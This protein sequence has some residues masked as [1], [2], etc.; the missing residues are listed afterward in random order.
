MYLPRYFLLF[1]FFLLI[2][3]SGCLTTPKTIGCC[4]KSRLDEG[5]YYLDPETEEFIDFTDATL[6]LCDDEASGTAG[7]CAVNFPDNPKDD[8]EGT[9]VPICKTEELSPCV[10][11]NCEA[12]LCGDFSFKPRPAKPSVSADIS[13]S[14]TN[15][16]EEENEDQVTNFYGASCGFFNTGEPIFGK[17]T[18]EGALA[19][20]FRFGFGTTF[21]EYEVFRYYFPASD[22][23]CSSTPY[24]ENKIDRYMNYLDALTGYPYDLENMP[25]CLMDVPFLGPTDGLWGNAG[26]A[27][28]PQMPRIYDF[29][30][31]FGSVQMPFTQAASYLF[32]PNAYKA[33]A[34]ESYGF[35]ELDNK[36]YKQGLLKAYYDKMFGS[37]GRAD[38]ECEFGRDE[39]Y[40]GSCS[41][42]DYSRIS[43]KKQDG[44]Y[45]AVDCGKYIDEKGTEFVFCPGTKSIRE[46]DGKLVPEYASYKVRPV[47]VLFDIGKRGP[48]RTVDFRD[49]IGEISINN[50]LFFPGE[51]K[52]PE[53]YAYRFSDLSEGVTKEAYLGW[54]SLKNTIRFPEDYAGYAFGPELTTNKPIKDI[55]KITIGGDPEDWFPKEIEYS[56]TDLLIRTDDRTSIPP[57]GFVFIG[58]LGND[59]YNLFV[60]GLGMYVIGWGIVSEEELKD[61][62]LIKA[63]NAEGYARKYDL[64]NFLDIYPGENNEP[65][66]LPR[67]FKHYLDY[68]ANY[69]ASISGQDCD[70]EII[71]ADLVLTSTPW[72]MYYEK[73]GIE[74][75]SI[76]FFGFGPP[77]ATGDQ[78][79]YENLHSF[80]TSLP[81]IFENKRNFF[82]Q[83]TVEFNGVDS[84]SIR[85]APTSINSGEKPGTRKIDLPGAYLAVAQDFYV[86]TAAKDPSEEKYYFGDCEVDPNTMLP[87]VAT[88]GWCE[89]CT[90]STLAYN[91]VSSINEIRRP[92]NLMEQNNPQMIY[93]PNSSYVSYRTEKYLKEGVLPIV[94]LTNVD[95]SILPS[96]PRSK[97]PEIYVVGD[98]DSYS[99]GEL[100]DRAKKIRN[101][102]DKC[103]IAFSIKTPGVEEI[104]GN[105]LDMLRNP[106]TS[107][108]FDLVVYEYTLTGYIIDDI[109]TLSKISRNILTING[110]GKGLP[111]IAAPV[112]FAIDLNP[113][114]VKISIEAIVDQQKVLVKSGL[115]GMVFDIVEPN[116]RDYLMFANA[117]LTT[118]TY[119][120]TNEFCAAQEGIKKY[121]SYE[122]QTLI[123]SMF[124]S[125]VECIPC[126]SLDKVSGRCI[127]TCQDGNECTLPS[128]AV[129]ENYRCPDYRITEECT[130]CSSYIS[131]EVRCTRTY[132]NG[133]AIE[134][135]YDLSE[136]TLDDKYRDV[137]AALPYGQKCC[138]GDEDKYS[139]YSVKLTTPATTPI[140]FPPDGNPE[141]PCLGDPPEF[142]SLSNICAAA[143]TPLEE[144][145]LECTIEGSTAPPII[146]YGLPEDAFGTT[147]SP[148]LDLGFDF[149]FSG[150]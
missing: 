126:S 56:E 84:C 66:A 41:I 4:D 91:N 118:N 90:A 128:G 37:E 49:P 39:C 42:S 95:T 133:T 40:S 51:R 147:I 107:L 54:V 50:W 131:G 142:G 72:I 101:N 25:S 38:F 53:Y 140:F 113:E 127:T 15:I 2:F 121:S 18:E 45:A 86:L 7:F 143:N 93:L 79:F 109:F 144:Y 87:K 122:T 36:L 111:S 17:I 70:D 10:S 26:P 28:K 8:E 92:F 130:P 46:V 60:P 97:G 9:L 116:N 129:A 120:K 80:Q 82:G 29:G 88:F 104:S 150:G 81:F 61:T 3:L 76:S 63:C 35:W 12:M 78:D 11:G 71:P 1:S 99:G 94:D 114:E 69:I 31:P 124:A 115:I 22:R 58:N 21:D 52:N 44:S 75:E 6:G 134:E 67:I 137:I 138:L 117:Q 106:L 43:I 98:V 33:G 123:Q 112:K 145:S 102:C 48:A 47:F 125:E 135:V 19:N 148:D 110:E 100:L 27:N 77:V 119:I 30:I 5:C 96:L 136:I 55:F 62:M 108:Y 105:A 57:S 16:P 149:G 141:T 24:D 85:N 14:E 139:Y 89:P 23:Y 13:N 34:T 20:V 68:R 32:E 103:L 132:N 73:V 74:V 146:K 59:N 65:R 64:S 83:P